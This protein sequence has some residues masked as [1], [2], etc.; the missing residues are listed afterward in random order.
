VDSLPAVTRALGIITAAAV[1]LLFWRLGASP[2]WDQDETKYAGI[3]REIV[4]TGDWMTLHW[5]GEPWFVHPPLW[6]WLTALAG[7]ALGFGEFTAR[8]W[9]AT[10]GAAGIGFVYLMGRELFGPRCGLVAAF[11]LATTVQWVAQGRLAV[12]DP[13]LVLWMLLA[14]RFLWQGYAQR[15]PRSYGWAFAAAGL[16][17]LTKGFVA[18]VLPAAAF[19]LFLALR[20]ELSRLRQV[21]WAFGLGVYALLGGGWYVAQWVLHGAMFARTALGYYTLNRY[22]GV[23]EGQ[24]GPLWYYVPVVILGGFPWSA[25]YPW[26]FAAALQDRKDPRNLLLC[27]WC[28]FVLVFFSVAGTKLPNYVLGLYP[29]ASLVVARFLEPA[30]FEH[31]PEFPRRAWALL[32][33]A[34]MVFGL[35]LVIYGLVQYPT[36]TRSVLPSLVLP[37]TILLGGGGLAAG[38]GLWGRPRAAVVALG[39][40]TLL[41]LVLG[42][43]VVV[44]EVDRHRHGKSVGR[45]AAEVARPGDARIGY[46]T[47]NSLVTYSGL[48]WQYAWDPAS[49]Q[50]AL[51]RVPSSRRAVV[52]VP[53][54]WYPEEITPVLDGSLRLVH[55]VGG[56]L[57]LESPSGRRPFCPRIRAD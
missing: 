34:C 1:A 44:P 12:F 9:S 15:V 33:G 8:F 49:L 13:L 47:L 11:V 4:R 26:A 14:L 38:L 22:F 23:V 7:R 10:S 54:R 51:C 6:F 57:I 56:H 46:R 36:E 18:A 39:V 27:I 55:R 48:S 32:G 2:L 16:G 37:L 52:V 42:I 50:D 24:S 5:N 35:A 30:L 28:G 40:S 45:A 43:G 19:L 20:R 41:F 17:T 31:D 53:E 21:P 25:L 29:V 3:S